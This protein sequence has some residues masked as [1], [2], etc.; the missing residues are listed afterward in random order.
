MVVVVV[1]GISLVYRR[2]HS[3]PSLLLLHVT[4]I[5]GGGTV[6]SLSLMPRWDANGSERERERASSRK[7]E[8][9]ETKMRR[10]E[11]KTICI[12]EGERKGEK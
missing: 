10:K 8:P 5:A 3:V 4:V 12:Y 11:E 9:E 7:R 6:A 1:Y 2:K